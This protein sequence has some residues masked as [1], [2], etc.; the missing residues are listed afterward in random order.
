MEGK[1]S[2]P[3][4]MCVY[5]CYLPNQMSLFNSC[6][7]GLQASLSDP[8]NV[9]FVVIGNKIDV[10]TIGWFQR[11]KLELGVLQKETFHTMKRLPKKA[12]M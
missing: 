10:E 7:C 11:R 1:V 4:G 2:D 8:E 9:P 5:S 3:A 12:P 6:Y